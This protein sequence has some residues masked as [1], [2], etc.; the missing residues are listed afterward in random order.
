MAEITDLREKCA[1]CSHAWSFHQKAFGKTC[2][3]MGC[4]GGVDQ[5]R[6]SGFVRA[7]ESAS[8]SATG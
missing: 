3:A 1:R 2:R 5:T 7:K 6:C 8:L 4:K